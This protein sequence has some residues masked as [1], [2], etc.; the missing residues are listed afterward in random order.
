[1]YAL[2]IL[3]LENKSIIYIKIDVLNDNIFQRN[4]SDILDVYYARK[5]FAQINRS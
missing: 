5:Y 3:H 1:M 4:L 2:N